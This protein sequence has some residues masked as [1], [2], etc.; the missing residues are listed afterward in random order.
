MPLFEIKRSL[1]D[2][3]QHSDV[4]QRKVSAKYRKGNTMANE[5]Q[6]MEKKYTILH[7]ERN[8]NKKYWLKFNW[9]Q[10]FEHSSYFLCHFTF[11][12]GRVFFSPLPHVRSMS[13]VSFWD[14][15][16]SSLSLFIINYTPSFCVHTLLCLLLSAFNFLVTFSHFFFCIISVVDCI[17]RFCCW[18]CFNFQHPRQPT[19]TNHT[20]FLSLLSFLCTH[21]HNILLDM[22]I[23]PRR[24]H[25]S[26]VIA[27]NSKMMV[28]EEKK[29]RNKMLLLIY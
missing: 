16:F 22:A 8:K 14:R 9:S 28:N 15:L 6:E 13:Y 27:H 3:D 25:F 11:S 20:F 12:D 7:D 24:C 10:S 18:F 29:R 1:S 23:T 2:K 19:T 21:M 4:L 26:F 17:V 5:M